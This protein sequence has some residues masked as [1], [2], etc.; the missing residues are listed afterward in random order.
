MVTTV[1]AEEVGPRPL[2]AYLLLHHGADAA[3]LTTALRRDS[4]RVARSLN[5][6]ARRGV[7]AAADGHYAIATE[8]R[9][10][11]ADYVEGALALREL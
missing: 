6:L 3:T 7:I 8:R 5:R 10:A 2:L 4:A 1:V 9:A 11:V